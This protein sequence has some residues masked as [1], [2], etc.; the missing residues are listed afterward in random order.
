MRTNRTGSGCNSTLPHCPYSLLEILSK[1]TKI[2]SQ[3]SLIF[4]KAHYLTTLLVANIIER[5]WLS[6]K[7][8]AVVEWHKQWKTEAL[9]VKSVSAPICP[10]QIPR[11]RCPKAD[12]NSPS[13][14]HQGYHLERL[15]SLIQ[16]LALRND[17]IYP[18][19]TESAPR[20]WYGMLHCAVV[21]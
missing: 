3:N 19:D 4:F 13:T 5:Q 10:P 11:G 18:L 6:S 2:L 14:S 21:Q 7:H 8:A 12:S 17:R 20:S 15:H 16:I 1:H 9:R